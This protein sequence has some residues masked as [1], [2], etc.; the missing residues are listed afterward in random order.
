MALEPDTILDERGRIMFRCAHCAEPMTRSDFFD[1]GMRLPD[2]GETVDD[3]RDAE[4][5]D[6]F[7]H[8]ACLARARAARAG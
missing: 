3:Y 2:R 4:L 8:G 5:I 1:L 7:E 6:R